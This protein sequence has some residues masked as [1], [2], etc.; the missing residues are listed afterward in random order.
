M[1]ALRW[2]LLLAV[3]G[4]ASLG[5]ADEPALDGQGRAMLDP[6]REQALRPQ[7]LLARLRLAPT[8]VVADIGAGPGFLTL[9]LARAVPRGRVVATDVRADYLAVLLA[10][11]K[12]AGATNVRTRVVTPER[13]GLEARSVDVALL[14]Q[15]DHQLADRAAYFAALVPAL[16]VGGR[17]VLVNYA[18]YRDA[19]LEAARRAGRRVGDEWAPSPPVFALVLVTES[20][21][22]SRAP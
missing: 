18:R 19:D 16:R 22:G 14:C 1:R 11:A 12:Q 3:I 5:R 7:A 4:G 2:L 8:A 21:G 13:P 15:V 20:S 17:I 6:I 10:R 9:P